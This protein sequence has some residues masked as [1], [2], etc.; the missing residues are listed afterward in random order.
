MGA[1]F[2]LFT[3]RFQDDKYISRNGNKNI[4][5]KVRVSKEYND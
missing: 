1:K 2:I 5:N 4:K 3:V